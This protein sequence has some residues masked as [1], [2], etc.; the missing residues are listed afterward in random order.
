[1]IVVDTSAWIEW[2]TGSPVGQSVAVRP[3]SDEDWLVPTMVQL[4]LAKWCARAITPTRADAVMAFAR[5]L[6]IIPLDSA[7]AL[8]AADV[9]R[10]H[11]LAT[12]DA[13]IYATALA[14]DADLL[15]AD[16]H[17][18]GLPRVVHVPKSAH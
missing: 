18:S 7:I 15:T 10:R 13:V 8:S 12:A 4:E 9:C 14:M 16:A 17:F 5:S 6:P 2:I 1:M 3:P 11:R